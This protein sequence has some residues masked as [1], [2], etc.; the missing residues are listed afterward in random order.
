MTP[1]VIPSAAITIENITMGD[2]Y[3]WDYNRGSYS[4]QAAIKWEEGNVRLRMTSSSAQISSIE[5][6]ERLADGSEFCERN[7]R[8]LPL[9]L[10][11]NRMRES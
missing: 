1:V 4:R 11:W 8:R 3:I 7:P 2:P 9:L 6:T 10:Y 5:Y